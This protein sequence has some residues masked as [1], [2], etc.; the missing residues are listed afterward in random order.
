MIFESKYMFEWKWICLT[1]ILLIWKFGLFSKSIVWETLKLNLCNL[2]EIIW[3]NH[4]WF[5][6]WIDIEMI[7]NWEPCNIN[8]L[9]WKL[10]NL[11]KIDLYKYEVD[12]KSID[13]KGTQFGK[14]ILYNRSLHKCDLIY[15][16]FGKYSIW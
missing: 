10:S 15:Y 5:W 12:L 11:Y 13:L 6:N 8:H 1:Y 3:W 2:E 4:I 16:W 7:S 14:R 9:I